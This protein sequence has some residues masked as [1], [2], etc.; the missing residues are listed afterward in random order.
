[1][2][3]KRGKASGKVCVVFSCEDEA[4][5]WEWL[6]VNFLRQYYVCFGGYCSFGGYCNGFHL[7]DWK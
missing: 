5:K 1:M 2:K 7:L 3:I 6:F 4:A